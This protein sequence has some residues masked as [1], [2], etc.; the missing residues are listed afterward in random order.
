MGDL[1]GFPD[2][3]GEVGKQRQ[4]S[5]RRNDGELTGPEMPERIL[6]AHLACQHL[7]ETQGDAFGQVRPEAFAHPVEG[8]EAEDH[9]AQVAPRAHRMRHRLG[10]LMLQILARKKAAGRIIMNLALALGFQILAGGRKGEQIVQA[11]QY[12]GA[13]GALGHEIGGAQDPHPFAFLLGFLAGNDDEGHLL[14]AAL[15][16]CPHPLQQPGAVQLGHLQIGDHRPDRM[17]EQQL[18]PGRLA[19]SLLADVERRLEVARKRHPHQS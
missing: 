19:V 6:G 2:A 4:R 3:L 14:Q 9:D 11:G 18:L 12:L 15:F 17:V 5:S 13:A 10:G 7:G 8:I 1:D 16:G